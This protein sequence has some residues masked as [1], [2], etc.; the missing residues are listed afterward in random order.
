M[1]GRWRGS[2]TFL[3]VGALLTAAGVSIASAAPAAFIAVRD[4]DVV[5]LVGTKVVCAAQRDGMLCFQVRREK[6]IA[7]SFG[8]AIHRDRRTVL[9]RFDAAGRPKMVARR[10]QGAGLSTR[11]IPLRIGQVTRLAGTRLDCAAVASQ[12]RPTV[13]CSSDDAKGP[14]PGT[15]AVLINDRMAAIGRVEQGC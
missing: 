7:G 14:I 1:P 2:Q 9:F 3:L 11:L 8:V 4:G 12:G 15:H 13:Y 6:P 10:P 5:D